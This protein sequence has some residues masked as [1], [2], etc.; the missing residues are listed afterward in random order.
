[1]KKLFSLFLVLIFF[2]SFSIRGQ[3]SKVSPPEN[4]QDITYNAAVKSDVMSTELFGSVGQEASGVKWAI[5]VRLRFGRKHYGAD[6]EAIKESLMQEKF[7]SYIPS[8]I[9]SSATDKA[10][11]PA[12]GTDFEANWSMVA[13][14]PDNSMAVSNGGY[15]VTANNDGVEYYNTSGSYLYFNYWS[16]FFNNSALTSMIYDPKVIY[17]ASA[18]RFVMAVLHGTTPAT[19]KVLVCFSKSN[20]PLNGWW[21]YTLSG[22]PLSDNSWFDY[23]GLGVSNNEIYITG[24]LFS[25]Q[26][27]FNQAI[28]YQIQKS[29]G[30]SGSNI[31]FQYWHSLN[32]TP[33]PAF[34]LVPAS[35]GQTGS[36]GP[37]IYLV[38]SKSGGDNRIRLWD[39]TDD[40]SGSPQVNSYTINVST[41]YSPVPNSS[42]P[43]TSNTLDNGDCR[44]QNAFYLN[45]LIHYVL[46]SDIGQGWNGIHYNRLTISNL[47]NQSATFGLQGSYDYSYPAVASFA[48]SSSDKSVMIAF[49]RASGSLYPEVRVVNC[50]NNMQWSG[51]VLVKSGE[52]YVNFLSGDQR[53]GDYTGIARK[54][55]SST[56][57]VWLAGCYGASIP[58][59]NVYNT[60][61]TWV[62]EVYGGA[63]ADI[64]E[65]DATE[66]AL[67]VFPNPVYDF[68][69][70]LFTVDTR[71]EVT[72]ELN[73]IEGRLIKLLY[74]DTPKPGENKLTF[75][76]GA[77]SRGT[78]FVTIKTTS[79]IIKNERIIIF[80]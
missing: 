29:N 14:P 61:K 53:W 6:I 47:S 73:D 40:M 3:N 67:S 8:D 36:Y 77:L 69:N 79:K 19:S 42:Q 78:Y 22:N 4:A 18:D 55:N 59:Q 48:T 35:L 76:K 75:N 26:G 70:V 32:A 80:D 17:D 38:S 39:I 13:T 60:Y 63:S 21:T 51:S 27:T 7:D 2:N 5:S 28:I 49:L 52:T 1:M 57:R 72:I 68:V 46:H 37:G 58:N 66:D 23:P 43:G 31:N 12:I 30:Y 34:S 71:E 33:Y 45:G 56:P 62:A 64:N 54:H 25:S 44:I 15:I 10:V 20:N 65:T 50:D 11:T 41:A 74:R 24:N 9:E 16:D